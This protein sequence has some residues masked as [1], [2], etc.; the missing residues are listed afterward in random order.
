MPPPVK[1]P[2]AS[3][4]VFVATSLAGLASI[5]ASQ[6]GKAQNNTPAAGYSPVLRVTLRTPIALDKSIFVSGSFNQWGLGD[7]AWPMTMLPDGSYAARLPTWVRGNYEFKFHLGGW[8]SEAVSAR[9]AKMGNFNA[10]FG[11]RKSMFEYV[12]V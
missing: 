1:V 2:P 8:E 12:I 7:K 9:G 3:R 11:P 10:T 4:R 6:T 5:A